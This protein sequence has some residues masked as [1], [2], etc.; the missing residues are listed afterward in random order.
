ML[1]FFVW[2][3]KFKGVNFSID[4]WYLKYISITAINVFNKGHYFNL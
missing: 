4:V 1:P 2:F 3:L